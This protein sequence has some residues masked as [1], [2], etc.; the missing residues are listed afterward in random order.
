MEGSVWRCR[1]E[2]ANLTMSPSSNL[3]RSHTGDSLTRNATSS[4]SL[5]HLA[6]LLKRPPSEVWATTPARRAVGLQE[7][8]EALAM[9]VMAAVVET[10]P[11]VQLDPTSCSPPSRPCFSLQLVESPFSDRYSGHSLFTF[12]LVFLSSSFGHGTRTR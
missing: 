6:L 11:V 10:L 3:G 7:A 5:F 4:L 12:I 2:S 9:V 8:V 1:G